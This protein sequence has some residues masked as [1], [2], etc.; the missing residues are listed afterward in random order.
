MWSFAG[1]QAIDQQICCLGSGSSLGGWFPALGLSSVRSSSFGP[2]LCGRGGGGGALGLSL[3]QPAN[4]AA[5]G[6]SCMHHQQIR[7]LRA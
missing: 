3:L 6:L 7:L 2:E 5:S 4:P 1:C